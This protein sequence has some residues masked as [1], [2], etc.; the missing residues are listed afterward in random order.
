MPVAPLFGLVLAGGAS[1][2]MQRDKAAL[3]YHGKP[4]LQWAYDQV[5]EFCAAT[6]ISVRPDQRADALRAT[7]PQIVDRKPGMGPLAGIEAALTEHPK[8]AWLVVGCDLPQLTPAI[9]KHLIE[10]RDPTR[11]A[12]AYRSDFDG[13]PEPLCAIWEPAS[14]T[15]VAEWFAKNKE[16]PRKL[17][18]NSDV[19]LVDLP[20]A[21]ALDNVNTPD[22]FDAV[23][24]G[25][26]S[27]GPAPVHT[28][29]QGNAR[30]IHVQYFAVFREQ[31]GRSEEPIETRARTPAELYAELSR[32]H[33]FKLAQQQVK[34]AV[35]D[36]FSSW[37]AQLRAGDRVV[38]I[39]PVAGG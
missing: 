18:I 8:A 5:S 19:A 1:K 2:R 12:T 33:P 20:V 27:S 39:P 4:Q 30:S 22:E 7:L 34:V 26:R 10:H 13:L 25:L 3:E 36:E 37:D 38:F 15:V 14:R 16:C 32:R 6:F 28:A 31:A 35:N 21:A 29:A 11:I 24:A 9:L 17:L 23:K